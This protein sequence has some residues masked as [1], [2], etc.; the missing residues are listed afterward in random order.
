MNFKGELL[1]KKLFNTIGIIL[2]ILCLPGC[3]RKNEGFSK[4]NIMLSGMN[5][6][7]VTAEIIVN[8]N[9]AA[10]SYNVK[11][12]FKYPDKYRLEVLNPADKRGKITAYDGNKLW[13]YQPG[14]RQFY[15]IE[16]YKE[17]EESTMF[18]G[19][20]AKKLFCGENAEYS[21]K[22]IENRDY[23]A[24]KVDMPGGNNYRKCQVMYFNRDSAVPVKMEI[25]DSKGNTSVTVYYREFSYNEKVDDK[26]FLIENLEG[27]H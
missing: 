9:R 19:Y 21:I 5:S 17:P 4:V 1:L 13:I 8:G 15:V 22:R 6:Y 14:I 2:I 16:N 24:V 25:L 27:I 3:G 12:Y 20:F 23:I 18:P 10:E 26:L 11:Q 7:T